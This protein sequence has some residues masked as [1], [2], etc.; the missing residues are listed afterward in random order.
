MK[1]RNSFSAAATPILAGLALTLTLCGC[2]GYQLGSTL[3]PDIQ[4]VCIPTFV[5]R[6]TEPQIEDDM[7][8]A[9]IAQVQLDG[10]LEVTDCARAD[11]ILTV[12]LQSYTV[13]AISYEQD[14]VTTAKEYRARVTASIV[15]RRRSTDEVIVD[16]PAVP[17]ETTF[18][19]IGDMSSS[20]RTALPSLSEDLANE[21]VN[22]VTEAWQ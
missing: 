4:S 1:S 5:N 22:R 14:D 21:I 20:K 13:D 10:S 15:L 2:A 11:T 9:T 12:I 18:L 7:S 3:P 17:G 8:D 6:T 16:D 19:V